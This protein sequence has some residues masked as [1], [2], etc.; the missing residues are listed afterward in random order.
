MLDTVR[1]EN[2]YFYS[3]ATNPQTNSNLE[4]GEWIKKW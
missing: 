4:K 1:P 2:Y 3:A